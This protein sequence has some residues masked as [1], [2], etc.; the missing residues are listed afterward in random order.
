MRLERWGSIFWPLLVGSWS[1]GVL[2]SYWG[3]SNEFII[4]LSKVVRVISPLQMDFWWQPMIFMV[5]SVLSIFVLSQVLLGLGGVILLF[6]R[7]MYDSILISQLGGII[8][9]WSFSN[10][11]VSEI[12]MILIL[13]LIIGVNLPL[14]IWSGRLGSQRSIYLFYRLRGENI[15]PDFGP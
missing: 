7:G 10:I 2:I 1:L 15:N 9:G 13:F 5:L 3:N 11:P 8:G 6:A 14:C 12:W 4:G